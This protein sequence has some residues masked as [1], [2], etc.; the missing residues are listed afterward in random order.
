MK[1]QRIVQVYENG[2]W[3]QIDFDKL[4][5]GDKFRLFESTGEQVVNTKGQKEWVSASSPFT[6]QYGDLMVNIY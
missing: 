2:T 1:D 4:R 5:E 3:I 6:N